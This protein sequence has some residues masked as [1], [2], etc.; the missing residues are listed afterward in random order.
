[1]ISFQTLA[2]SRVDIK[3][4]GKNS[5]FSEKN[6]LSIPDFCRGL[7][8]KKSLLWEMVHL[9]RKWLVQI[10]CNIK[11]HCTKEKPK[12][13]IFSTQKPSKWRP[14]TIFSVSNYLYRVTNF[15]VWKSWLWKSTKFQ[16][17]FTIIWMHCLE[18]WRIMTVLMLSA[19]NFYSRERGNFLAVRIIIAEK[20]I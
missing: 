20:S 12:I 4:K 10:I 15:R 8:A 5:Q 6:C 3:Q 18:L 17:Q 2:V 7:W 1:M 19:W 14:R 16:V 9:S 13:C 11:W